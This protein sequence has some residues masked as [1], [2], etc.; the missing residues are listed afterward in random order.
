MLTV[1]EN[2]KGAGEDGLNVESVE[3][4]G[5]SSSPDKRKIEAVVIDLTGLEEPTV[6]R[7]R[8]MNET[9]QSSPLRHRTRDEGIRKNVGEVPARLNSFPAAT[10]KEMTTRMM[11]IGDTRNGATT[12]GRFGM[13]FNCNY[14][15]T[16]YYNHRSVWIHLKETG[17]L[18]EYAGTESWKSI[19]SANA[20]KVKGMSEPKDDDEDDIEDFTQNAT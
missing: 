2:K 16:A 6:K 7:N 19:Y 14:G 13:V 11:W 9:E 18:A 10:L 12:K 4:S 20:Y 1:E 5:L 8:F 3:K 17:A 15:R